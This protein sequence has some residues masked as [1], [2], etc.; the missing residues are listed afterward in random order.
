MQRPTSSVCNKSSGSQ[1]TPTHFCPSNPQAANPLTQAGVQ[2][3]A[4]GNRGKEIPVEVE[5]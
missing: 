4:A 1:N 2:D 5:R 3:E